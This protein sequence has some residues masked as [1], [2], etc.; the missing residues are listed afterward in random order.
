M[1]VG[2]LSSENITEQHDNPRQWA[3]QNCQIPELIDIRSSLINSR[4][5]SNVKSFDEKFIEITKE[6]SQAEKPVEINLNKKPSFRLTYDQQVTPFGPSVKLEKAKIT[7]NP[8]IPRAVDKVVSETDL[9]TVD[10]M[11]Y[12]YKKGYD[13]HYLTK[14]VSVGNLGVGI[15]RKITPTRWSITATDDILGKQIISEIKNYQE[16]KYIAHFGGYLGNYYLILFFPEVW[17]YELFE[18]MI[19]TKESSTDFENYNGRKDYASNTV[20]GYYAAR[21]AILE[22]LKNTKRQASVL[23]LRF[24]SEEYWAP[25]GVWVVRESVRHTLKNKPLQFDS[26]ELMLKYAKVLAQKKFNFDLNKI[27]ETSVL[28]K[29]IKLQRKLTSFIKN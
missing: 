8:A 26:K 15:N 19:A 21:L 1:N 6:V 28:L 7:E 10:A 12:L 23:A 27:L 3:E 4:F 29:N 24:I 17:S 5:R 20:G 9:K 25:L 18:T 22:Y 11:S 14:L 16:F 2:I 13:E